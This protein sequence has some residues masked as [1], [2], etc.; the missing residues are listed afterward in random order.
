M[1]IL[2]SRL[3]YNGNTNRY[4]DYEDVKIT[5]PGFGTTSIL[6]NF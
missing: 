4:S 5:V 6:L 1:Y 3:N 2:D